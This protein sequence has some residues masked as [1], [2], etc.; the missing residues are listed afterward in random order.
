MA[1]CLDH[2]MHGKLDWAG[3][4]C[5]QAVEA[6]PHLADAYKLRAYV[7]LIRH[8]FERA[9]DDFRA[10]LQLKPKDDQNIAGYHQA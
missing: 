1:M 9:S 10:A 2:F 3:P 6:D 4:A 7:R 5:G 8:R